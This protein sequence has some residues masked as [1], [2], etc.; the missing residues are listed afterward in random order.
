M[1]VRIV[2]LLLVAVGQ[3]RSTHSNFSDSCLL[4]TKLQ[5]ERRPLDPEFFD[6]DASDPATYVWPLRQRNEGSLF[7]VNTDGAV[8]E[9]KDWNSMADAVVTWTAQKVNTSL[10]CAD[11][12]C[13]AS[14]VLQAFDGATHRAQS[15]RLTLSLHPTDFDDQYSGERL[16]WVRINDVIVNQDCFPMV[17]GCNATTQKTT[18]NCITDLSLDSIINDTGLL[19]ISTKIPTVVDECP[20]EGNLLS[21]IPKVECM[22]T[23]IVEHN[24]THPEPRISM[25]IVKPWPQFIYKS[26]KLQCMTRNCT[27]ETFLAPAIAD[28]ENDDERLIASQEVLPLNFSQCLLNVKVY[29]TDF[30]QDQ[31][32]SETVEFVK[33]GGVIAGTNVAPGGNPCRAKW[34]GTSLA[35]VDMLFDA[36]SGFDVTDEIMANHSVKI[37]AKISE[38]VD[39]CAYE[40]YLLNG[41]VEVNCSVA[42]YAAAASNSTAA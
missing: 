14:A 23:P 20:Y 11:P 42:P 5:R 2:C 18:F 21:A 9:Q 35:Q 31:G 16:E 7:R 28:I 3:A 40:G 25:P 15:C 22:V 1:V 4:Q 39:E 33:V 27:A 41:L 30:D 32:T 8:L 19:D 38:F 34:N 6:G 13:T 26:A 24:V 17:S 29:Q 10:T 37:Q 12:G 36:V